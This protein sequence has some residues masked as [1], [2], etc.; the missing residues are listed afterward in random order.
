M[1]TNLLLPWLFILEKVQLIAIDLSKQQLL[2][3][4]PKVIDYISFR[5]NLVH[6]GKATIFSII[7]EVNKTMW[8]F[9]TLECTI[10]TFC[11]LYRNKKNLI[12]GKVKVNSS[13]F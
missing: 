5:E 2:D 4:D 1:T 12:S 6:S 11:E 8:N 13:H 7:E 9:S 3:T 10:N